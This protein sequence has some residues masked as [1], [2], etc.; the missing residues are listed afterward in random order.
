ML[1]SVAATGILGVGCAPQVPHSPASHSPSISRTA[2]PTHSPG[3]ALGI[4]TSAPPSTSKS[5]NHNGL[6]KTRLLAANPKGAALTND[7]KLYQRGTSPDSYAVKVTL[8]DGQGHVTQTAKVPYQLELLTVLPNGLFLLKENYLD[9]VVDQLRAGTYD[10]EGG[11][12]WI[13]G[14]SGIFKAGLDVDKYL[15]AGSGTQYGTERIFAAG[16][17]QVVYFHCYSI[18]G[19]DRANCA[20]Y[21]LDIVSG[22]RQK[23]PSKAIQRY[24]DLGQ[25]V[26][27][28]SKVNMQVSNDGNT[29][30]LLDV[31]EDPSSGSADLLTYDFR[32]GKILGKHRITGL[33]NPKSRYWI[34]PT[35]RT[36]AY[37]GVAGNGVK[38]V[39][40]TDD[41][42]SRISLRSG[43]PTSWSGE[44]TS[45]DP[46]WSPDGTRIAFISRAGYRTETLALLDVVKKTSAAIATHTPT[47]SGTST[48]E[49]SV[50]YG[51]LYW[52]NS[53]RITFNEVTTAEALSRWHTYANNYQYD[54]GAA[55]PKASP[56]TMGALIGRA[57][58]SY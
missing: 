41:Q 17:R 53:S 38:L 1:T 47:P 49:V 22:Q 43:S 36:V 34:S 51:N 46:L 3:N 15:R 32:T 11:R 24:L 30:Y 10:H 29:L 23:L 40:V 25:D 58:G 20:L 26:G 18:P 52:R 39:N 8:V 28:S 55:S 13:A 45:A 56:P 6:G 48:N 7:Y 35:G 14:R 57:D 2:S 44:T 9:V 5:Q 4:S 19:T 54:V 21:L 42:H 37:T 12:F 50:Q 27:Q 33:D 31:S 16:P